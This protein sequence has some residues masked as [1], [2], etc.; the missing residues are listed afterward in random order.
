MDRLGVNGLTYKLVSA[1]G[2][3]ARVARTLVGFGAGIHYGVHTQSLKNLARGIAERVLY[4]FRNGS[5]DQAPQPVAGVFEKRLGPFRARLLN[6]LSRT[7][8]VQRGEY[9]LLYNG[10]KQEIYKK[11][12]DSL[13]DEAVSPRDAVVN[14]FVKAEKINFTSK[15]DPAPRVIQ[16]RSP[17]YNVEVGRYLK[18]FEKELVRGFRRACGYEVILKGMNAEGTA[19]ALR[20]DW[21]AYLRPVAVGLDASRFDQHVSVDALKWEHSVYNGV[22]RSKEL[23]GLLEWQ[24][25]NRGVGYAEGMKVQYEV[26]GRR[27][28]GD[29]NTGMGNCLLMSS[30]VLSYIEDRGINAR[31]ANNGDDC[32]VIME[33]SDLPAFD[34]IDA[35][36]LDF[37]FT[38]TREEPVHVFERI[39]FCQAQPVMVNGVWRMVRNPLVAVSKDMVS[40]KGWGSE[41]EIRYW[42]HSV[43]A[44]GAAL[45][46]G[47]PVTGVLYRRLMEHGLKPSEAWDEAGGRSGA[48]YMA[49][50]LS[51]GCT[52]PDDDTRVSFYKAFGILPDLQ[53]E[54]ELGAANLTLDL[55]PEMFLDYNSEASSPLALLNR[56]KQR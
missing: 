8:V 10:R 38:L 1:R 18:L 48:W 34:G 54:L 17:R 35:W 37:G 21:D 11:A 9:P 40:L 36:M 3:A 29:I 5:P 19:A 41:T 13:V 50:D 56:I 44:C 7:P 28:S 2:R 55:R 32:V 43:G 49:R 51:A 47:V 39:E 42:L 46:C 6:L 12:V 23:A 15:G 30:M 16:P 25:R 52:E 53:V 27:M 31:L 4:V 26:D 45:N 33:S 20:A 24:L 22:F 14:T